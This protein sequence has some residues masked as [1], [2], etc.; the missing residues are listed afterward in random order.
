MTGNNTF[1]IALLLSTGWA[2]DMVEFKKGVQ[3]GM[4]V[5][6]EYLS[7]Y[8]CPDPQYSSSLSQ[9]LQVADPVKDLLKQAP[10]PALL[11]DSSLK[12]AKLT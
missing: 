5:E 9:I 11:I 8:S 1:V 4:F 2:F 10:M 7:D 12:L 3:S 6:K